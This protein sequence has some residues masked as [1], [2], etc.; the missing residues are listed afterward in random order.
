M[1]KFHPPV[2]LQVYRVAQWVGTRNLQV[3]STHE[4]NI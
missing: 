2:F 3:V 1:C 4:G